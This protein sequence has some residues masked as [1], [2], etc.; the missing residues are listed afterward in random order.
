MVYFV[1]DLGMPPC[2][3][4]SLLMIRLI[5]S[6]FPI[7]VLQIPQGSR[8]IGAPDEARGGRAARRRQRD[9]L[10]FNQAAEG[11]RGP[12]VGR[13]VREMD[14]RRRNSEGGW[15]ES[16]QPRPRLGGRALDQVCLS[17]PWRVP[18]PCLLYTSPS[19]RD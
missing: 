16:H 13:T 7:L 11:N 1:E 8:D 3:T 9:R 14:L 10:D 17:V 6:E 5:C 19:P 2:R 12:N 15:G 18:M 4:P